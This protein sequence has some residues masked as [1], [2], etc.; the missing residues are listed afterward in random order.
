MAASDFKTEA[1]HVEVQSDIEL[2]DG[3][4]YEAQ[5]IS[6]SEGQPKIQVIRENLRTVLITV[7][8]QVKIYPDTSLQSRRLRCIR[9]MV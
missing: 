2:K 5:Q 3:A 6:L 4:L 1:V 8:T 7:I 9:P